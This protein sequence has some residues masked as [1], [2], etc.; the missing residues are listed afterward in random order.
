LALV[1]TAAS[2]LAR[3]AWLFEPFTHFRLQVAAGAVLP[4]AGAVVR[5]RLFAASLAPL[6]FTAISLP[7]LSW[8]PAAHAD[9]GA[10]AE[11]GTGVRILSANVYYRHFDYAAPLEQVRAVDPGLLGLMEVDREWLEGLS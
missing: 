10:G 8:L 3:T 7:L 5:R 2:L 1:V 9:L 4:L 6:A 11:G